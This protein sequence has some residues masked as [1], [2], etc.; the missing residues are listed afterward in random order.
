[1]YLAMALI[2]P[3]IVY[4]AASISTG[5][6]NSRRV[7]EVIGPMEANRTRFSFLPVWTRLTRPRLSPRSAMKL[8]TVDELVKVITLGHSLRDF[9][10]TR[11][12]LREA[13]GITVS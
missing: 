13:S 8:R 10:A 12:L 9:N 1:M 3:G 2:R 6:P 11:S 7:D 4:S 5:K